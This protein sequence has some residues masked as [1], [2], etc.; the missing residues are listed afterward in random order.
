MHPFLLNAKLEFTEKRPEIQPS[1]SGLIWFERK[2]R[3]RLD[4]LGQHAGNRLYSGDKNRE[5]FLGERNSLEDKK[6]KTCPA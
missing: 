6:R 5:K 1:S 3:K 4:M 2:K